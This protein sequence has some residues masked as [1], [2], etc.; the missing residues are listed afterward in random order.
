MARYITISSVGPTPSFPVLEKDNP[1]KLVTGMIDYWR[2]R[3][4]GV[5]PSRPD[6]IVL[7]EMCDT[8]LGDP[9]GWRNSRCEATGHQMLDM[10]RET[11]VRHQCYIV[12]PTTRSRGDGWSNV[13]LVIDRQ[14]NIAGEYRKNHLTMQEMQNGALCGTEAPLI[15]C[16]FGT[17][18]IAICFDLNFSEL[19]LHYQKLRPDILIFPSMYHGGLMQSYWAYFCEAHFVG[20]MSFITLPNEIYS[21][22]GHLL[23]SNTN[24]DA[25]VTA[26][27]NLDCALIHWDSHQE[28]MFRLK[29][30]YGD[31]VDIFDPGKLAAFLISSRS[32]TVTARQMLRE[33]EMEPLDDFLHRSLEVQNGQRKSSELA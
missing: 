13:A 28:K 11:A 9:G 15:E 22:L 18:G 8:Y 3:I 19:R 2:Q 25:N 5:L 33:F 30:K 27:I 20:C 21:P 24:Y 6:L 16:D 23:A 31:E 10:L 12:Y 4:A 7:P 14:G 1:E 29:E 26:R 32:E 17:L